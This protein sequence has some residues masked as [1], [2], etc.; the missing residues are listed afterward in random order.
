[1]GMAIMYIFVIS[2]VLFFIYFLYTFSEKNAVDD[3]GNPTGG[4][5]RRFF[6][7]K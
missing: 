7:L 5:V 6:Y 3:D 4:Q 1:M 2:L